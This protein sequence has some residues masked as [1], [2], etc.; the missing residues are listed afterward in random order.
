MVPLALGSDTNGSIRVPGSLCG[1]F[2]LKPTYGRLSRTGARLFAASLD[3]VGPLARSVGDL[4][5]A[6]DAMQG[7]DPR[8]P[9]CARRAVEPS[10]PEIERGAA[11]P[12][13]AAPPGYFPPT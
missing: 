4:A 10:L 2:G 12:R 11:G 1:I 6:Y 9:A 8:D 3:H 5:A 13:I 7:P